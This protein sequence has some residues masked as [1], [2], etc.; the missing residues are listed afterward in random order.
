MCHA[1]F[2]G[3]GTRVPLSFYYAVASSPRLEKTPSFP[4]A[5]ANVGAFSKPCFRQGLP[6]LGTSWPTQKW[7]A[8]NPDRSWPHGEPSFSWVYPRISILRCVQTPRRSLDTPLLGRP[9]GPQ[10]WKPSTHEDASSHFVSTKGPTGQPSGQVRR[11]V[12]DH[13]C[14]ATIC[15]P[16]A[17]TSMQPQIWHWCESSSDAEWIIAN[18]NIDNIHDRLTVVLPISSLLSRTHLLCISFT[19]CFVHTPTFS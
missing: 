16:G 17:V 10:E 6:F 3:N 11:A 13:L 14:A 18:G 1:P 15:H 12:R 2:T 19:R 7:V 8:Q 4:P 9:R 5:G